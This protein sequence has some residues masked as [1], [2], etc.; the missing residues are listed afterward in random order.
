MQLARQGLQHGF[1][2]FE[3]AAGQLPPAWPGLVAGALAQQQQ[4]VAAQNEAGGDVDDLAFSHERG[5]Q[6][7]RA[8]QSR[9]N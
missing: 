5:G 3:L 8:A 7:W 1:A 6:A 4:A 9:A 2:G